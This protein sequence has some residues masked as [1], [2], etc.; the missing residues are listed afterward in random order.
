MKEIEI[1][2]LPKRFSGL[3][4]NQPEFKRYKQIQHQLQLMNGVLVRNYNIGP[5]ADISSTVTVIP[6]AMKMVLLSQVND[7]AG[8]QGIE[9]TLSRLKLIGYWVNMASYVVNYVAS[10]EVCQRAK[11]SLPT[12]APLKNTPMV[13]TMQMFQVDVLEVPISSKGI[14]I[15][16]WQRMHFQSG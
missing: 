9:R 10:C 8:H 2:P 5:F 13:R 16:W 15:S 14:G 11:L 6:D 4:W 7:E 12:G 3:E 1:V